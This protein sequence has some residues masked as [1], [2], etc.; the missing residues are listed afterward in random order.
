MQGKTKITKVKVRMLV[1]GEYCNTVRGLRKLPAFLHGIAWVP[2]D[3]FS[4]AIILP[5]KGWEVRR[6]NR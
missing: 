1:L 2:I 3:S 6:V 5:S 4:D